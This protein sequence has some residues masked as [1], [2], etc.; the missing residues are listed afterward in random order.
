MEPWHAG[1]SC[2]SSTP[3]LAN[4]WHRNI[5]SCAEHGESANMSID[6]GAEL[7]KVNGNSSFEGVIER[8]TTSGHST[9][10]IIVH[11]F[12]TAVH[13]YHWIADDIVDKRSGVELSENEAERVGRGVRE[14]DEA[15]G[16]GRLEE[17][18][19]VC[20]SAVRGEQLVAG[21][22]SVYSRR[23][24]QFPIRLTGQTTS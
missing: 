13:L 9:H 5:H 12:C 24:S 16:C 21:D 11:P 6:G 20:G 10:L 2:C 15:V 22:V 18:E 7:R 4:I 3:L 17:V 19:L 8:A 14:E 23:F 1:K